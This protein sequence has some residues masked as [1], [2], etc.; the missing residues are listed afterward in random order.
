MSTHTT[1]IRW[2]RI[3]SFVAVIAVL[4]VVAVAC[5]DDSS[6]GSGGEDLSISVTSPADG[7]V[8]GEEFEV[9]VDTSVPIGETDTGRHHVHLYFDGETAEGE[10]DIV[11]D[12]PFTVTR[13]LSP[14]EHTVEAVIANADHS[15]TDARQE[16]TV[17]VDPSAAGGGGTGSG[18]EGEPTTSDPDDTSGIP[19]Y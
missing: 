4:A 5:G 3:R 7:A 11:Y 1:P 12:V 17:T 19:G 8:V 6:G 2:T 13:S 16:F 10:Y 9:D 14:G 18:G 15:T